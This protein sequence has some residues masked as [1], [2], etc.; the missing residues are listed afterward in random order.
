MSIQG[1]FSFLVGLLTQRDYMAAHPETETSSLWE[2]ELPDVEP[3]MAGW[4][5]TGKLSL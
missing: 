5:G 2:T 4:G 1:P 3:K